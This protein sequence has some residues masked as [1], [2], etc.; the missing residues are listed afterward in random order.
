MFIAN[1][2]FLLAALMLATVQ[3]CPYLAREQ[4][5][6]PNQNLRRVSYALPAPNKQPSGLE[7]AIQMAT[8]QIAQ[9]ITNVDG[10]EAKFVRLSFH[11]CVGGCDGCVDLKNPSN[12]GLHIPIEAL[13]PVVQNVGA[14]LTIGDVWAL[15]GSVAARVSQKDT[16]AQFPLQFVGRPQCEGGAGASKAGPHRQL[17]SAHFTT[18]Q[19]TAFFNKTFGFSAE[20]SAAILGSHS[21]Y[22]FLAARACLYPFV[23]W[24]SRPFI[25]LPRG[26]AVSQNSG[27]T[28]EQGWDKQPDLLTNDYYKQLLTTKQ[29]T[30]ILE[31]NAPSSPFPD[32]FYW[33]EEIGGDSGIFMLHA[34]MSLAFDMEGHMNPVNGNVTCRLEKTKGFAVCP[35]SALRSQA[36]LYRKSNDLWVRDFEAAFVKMVN[37]GCGNGVCQSLSLGPTSSLAK[38]KG[39]C[40]IDP[41]GFSDC[42]TKEKGKEWC[43]LSRGNCLNGCGGFWCAA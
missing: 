6:Q 2:S 23:T 40:K 11:D 17:P 32:Q 9:I 14:F 38:D 22:V 34:D 15:A 18:K 42:K 26:R 36:E 21:L 13:E 10:M 35:T 43:S 31:D 41:A 4:D 24:N 5:H 3:A 28:G 29:W 37:T 30:L 19:V 8:T 33:E 1:G 25:R 39:H 20:E 7:E 27:F 12:F 16:F